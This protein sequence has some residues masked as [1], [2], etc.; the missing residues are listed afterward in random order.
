MLLAPGKQAERTYRVFF[1]I[2]IDLA[3]PRAYLEVYQGTKQLS[4]RWIGY[5]HRQLLY[6]Q[7]T[8]AL[9]LI[10]DWKIKAL[11]GKTIPVPYTSPP[12]KDEYR[13]DPEALT[14]GPTS[15][16]ADCVLAM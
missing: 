2:G 9:Y 14:D 15:R 16:G 10:Y 4:H 11:S 7:A 5:V 8:N 13:I 6:V 1:P 12:G 3:D